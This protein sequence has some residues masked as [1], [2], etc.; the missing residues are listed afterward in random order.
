MRI[1]FI[2]FSPLAGS[3]GSLTRLRLLAQE[4]SLQRDDVAFSASGGVASQLKNEGFHVYSQPSSTLLGL[5]GCI[6]RIMEKHSASGELPAKE[7]TSLGSIW[8]IY[9][10]T[11]MLRYRYLRK[12]VQNQKRNIHAFQP[13]F[14]VTEMDPGAYISAR[15]TETPLVTTYSA[16]ARHGRGRAPW[17]RARRVMNLVLQNETVVAEAAPQNGIDPEDLAFAPEILKIIPSVPALDPTDPSRKDIFFSGDLH[18]PLSASRRDSRV[19]AHESP[20]RDA[21]FCYFGT[22]SLGLKRVRR[23]LPRAL[24]GT[25]LTAYV[26]VPGLLREEKRGSVIFQ[27]FVEVKKILPRCRGV[28]CHGGLNTITQSLAAGV[29]L[30]IFP[31]PLF[32]RRENAR[33]AEEAGCAFVG[34]RSQFKASWLRERIQALKELSGVSSLQA[35]LQKAPGVKG[36]VAWIKETLP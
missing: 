26:G 31:G 17:Q 23:E 16:V 28:I 15:L 33:R 20:Q 2:V 11:G 36:C 32:E 29:P 27:P 10:M 30:I 1:L 4:F 12:L 22:G 19:G 8:M 25:G 5:P 35:A 3:F 21:L 7:G 6:S 9:Q 14:I 34:E 13:D 24:E 18:G